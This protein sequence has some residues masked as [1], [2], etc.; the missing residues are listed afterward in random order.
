[1]LFRIDIQKIQ[2]IDHLSLELDLAT[3]KLTCIVG[4]N[5]IGKTTLVRA[6][7]NLSQSDTFLRTAPTGV[8]S[9]E[10][11]IHY[12]VD[13]IQVTFEF[14]EHIGTINC[15]TEIPIHMRSLC[16]VELPIP[17]GDRFNFFQS[18]SRADRH[19][20][21]SIILEEYSHPVELIAFLSDIY[22]SDK[23][24]SLIEIKIDDRSYF[25]ILLD[26]GRYIREDYLSSGEY[27]LINL[28]RMIKGSAR[29][30]VVDEIDISLDA[31]AQVQ[32]LK[33]LRKFCTKY[34]CNILFTTHSLAMMRMLNDSE[35]FY[36][37]QLGVQTTISPVSYS[38][39]KSLLFGFSGWD[40]YI[41]TEDTVLAG[42]LEALVR[43]YFV[44]I[45]YKYK[46]IHVGGGRQVVDL[47]VRNRTEKFLA[48]AR[49][50]IAVLDGDQ[51]AENWAN[52]TGVHCLPF[53]SVEKAL[54]EYYKE[55]DFPYRLS[56]KKK[57]NSPKHLF[58]LLVDDRV[59]SIEMINRYMCDKNKLALKPLRDVLEKFLQ[60]E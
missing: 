16:K 21:R 34:N 5:G 31:A 27:F 2:H 60:Q 55:N 43:R 1:M 44:K 20:R 36:M 22:S 29:L 4:R 56:N 23:F 11:A 14:D 30:V 51:R 6:L 50:V 42:F 33:N 32:L 57:H 12:W 54:Y 18:I 37:E 49:N 28:Y 10:S 52:E 38:Y 35:L 15:R 3:N 41:L 48:E 53:E 45:F 7:R 17:Y 24:Q 40:R 26:D 25:C 19:I 47:L 59:M 13:D 9:Y 8:F 46:I 39:V 58:N